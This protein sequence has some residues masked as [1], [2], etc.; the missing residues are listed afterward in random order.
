VAR[1]AGRRGNGDAVNALL[2]KLGSEEEKVWKSA[3]EELEYF[4][5][6]LGFELEDLMREVTDP[7]TRQRMVEVMSGREAGSMAGHD[8][9][10]RPVG[11][12]GFNF[13]DG[14]ASWWA[15]HLVSRLNL[16]AWANPKKKWTRA[17]RAIILL[18]H[19]GTPEAVAILKD[20]SDGH[21]DAQPTAIANEAQER[22][23]RVAR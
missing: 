7:A 21:P 11:D 8:I 12:G 4:D 5:P 15:E 2:E 20:M 6:R 17:V 14:R 3:F 1:P 18:E 13:F 10:I 19:F 9:Q 22:L 23:A 16:H